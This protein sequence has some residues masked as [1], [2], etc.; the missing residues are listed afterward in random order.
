MRTQHVTEWWTEPENCQKDFHDD[1]RN[2][3]PTVPKTIINEEIVGENF[4]ERGISK[5]E[6]ILL[7]VCPSKVTRHVRKVKTQRS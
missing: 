3:Q 7:L 1:D 5:Y 6:T 4:E 2:C